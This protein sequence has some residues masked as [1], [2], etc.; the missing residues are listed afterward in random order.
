MSDD[1]PTDPARRRRPRQISR[2]DFD[3]LVDA[4]AERTGPHRAQPTST[5]PAIRWLQK[6][7]WQVS[8]W[9]AGIIAAHVLHEV[10]ARLSWRP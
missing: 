1:T 10:I 3:D 2:H 7:W 5:P 4:V 6:R 9:A 8:L